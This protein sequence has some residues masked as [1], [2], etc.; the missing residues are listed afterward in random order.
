MKK[1]SV[2]IPVYNAERH[3]INCIKS[4]LNQDI[5]QDFLEDV[6]I[7][8]INDGSSDKSEKI[9]KKFASQYPTII[10][11]FTK[12]NTGVADTRNLGIE[13]ATGEYIL[14]L[15]SDDYLD[16]ALFRTIKIYM[17]EKIEL[18]KYKLQRVDEAGRLIEFVPGATFEKI[19]G[20]EGFNN[21]YSSDVLLDSPCVYIIKRT[22]FM[23][24][25]LKFKVGAE[26]E[27]FGLIPFVV[28]LA[29]SMVSIN[30]YGYYYVQSEESITRTENE[31]RNWKKAK[32]VL[33][34]YD[35][36]MKKAEILYK[37]PKINKTTYENLKIFYTNALLNK[38]KSLNGKYRQEYIKE[39]R[40]RKIQ[41]NI[42][43]RNLKQ[44]MKKVILSL[45]LELY[46]KI[47]KW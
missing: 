30:F 25:N 43:A 29:K 12:E 19:K 40:K 46:L 7:V 32:D 26:H 4:V 44:L 3:L 10:K 28:V 14:F 38:A 21:L 33:L 8:L 45:N 15:D 39:L 36:A 18:I 9:I 24:N 5:S 11:Y 1:I 13:K 6:E 17:E 41:K 35:N 37:E 34:H 16:R 22:I 20:E 23:E 47:S 42:K 2:I 31:E 27:D